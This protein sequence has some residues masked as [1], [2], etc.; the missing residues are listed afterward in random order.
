MTSRTWGLE[1]KQLRTVANGYVRGALEYAAAAWMPATSSNHVELVER[2]L[3]AAARAVTGC[4]AST[5]VHAL[6]SEAGMTGAGSRAG[7]GEDGGTGG[8]RR[9]WWDWRHPYR[10]ETHCGPWARRT[11]APTEDE[12]RVE[13]GGWRRVDGSRRTRRARRGAPPPR[14]APMTL[15][16]MT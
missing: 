5:P 7:G 10:K 9:G 6:M 14:L 1:E 15:H 8:W 13:G 16:D 2:E 4:T 11:P 3:R 12:H